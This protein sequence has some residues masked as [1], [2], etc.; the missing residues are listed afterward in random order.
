MRDEDDDRECYEC[1]GPVDGRGHVC[2]R[3]RAAEREIDP[4]E[5]LE[6]EREREG[7][8][9]AA[10]AEDAADRLADTTEEWHAIVAGWRPEDGERMIGLGENPMADVPR[11]CIEYPEV[12]P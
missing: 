8:R 9:L 5:R 11:T 10:L 7:V 1:G 3:C 6:A 2:R 12:D 4:D